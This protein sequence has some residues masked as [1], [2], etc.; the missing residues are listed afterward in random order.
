[1]HA[2]LTR[3]MWQRVLAVGIIASVALI[4]GPVTGASAATS[5]VS[6]VTISSSAASTAKVVPKVVGKTAYSAKKALTK[7]GLHYKYS[8]PAGS[9]V[10]L[11]K[12]W[13]VTKQSPKAGSKVAPGTT[14]KLTVVKTSTLTGGSA[15]S[16]STPP[17]P[18]GPAL[19]VAQHQAALAAAGYLRLGSGF[20]YQ[21]L[22]DQLS[23]PYGNGFSVADAT[24]A[25]NSLNADYNAQAVLAAKGYLSFGG[26]SHASLV[27]QLTS[28]YGNQF[29][30][31]QGEYAATQVGL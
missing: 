27:E 28:A 5:G 26:F 14:V 10:V 7:A 12:N 19:T 23:S 24:V 11:S 17:P 31:A 16:K 18:A 20:S 1:M 30:A 9:F 4:L 29:T 21:G 22:I 3:T 13:T 15:G 2:R 8:A 25:V 6:K